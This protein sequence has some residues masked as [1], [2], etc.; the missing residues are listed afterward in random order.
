MCST[1]FSKASGIRLDILEQ[2]SAQH[3]VGRH[4]LLALGWGS[5]IAALSG[6][7]VDDLPHP[8]CQRSSWLYEAKR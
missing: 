8:G 4:T 5:L 1:Q 2:S 3:T 6:L 7:D